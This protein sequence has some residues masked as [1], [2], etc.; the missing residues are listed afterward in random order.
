MDKKQ[1]R[2]GDSLVE[3]G[4]ITSEQLQ[5]ALREQQTTKKFL[6]SILVEKKEIKE[7][8]LLGVLSEQFN[9]PFISIK[10]KYVDWG[11]VKKFSPSLIL[12]YKCFPIEEDGDTV[13][14]AITNPLDAWGLKKAE[15]ETWGSR[16][17]LVLVS[18]DDMKDIIERYREYVQGR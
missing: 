7:R 16:L 3:K 14:V 4:L 8:D 6:G 2:L 1:K 18:E 15:E 9:I 5:D 10:Y 13:T 17:K 12:D 11:F